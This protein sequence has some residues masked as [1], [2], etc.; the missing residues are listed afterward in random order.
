MM[1]RNK[2]GE[3][4]WVWKVL[5]IVPSILVALYVFAYTQRFFVRPIRLQ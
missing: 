3:I 4:R 5:P 2:D 1:F